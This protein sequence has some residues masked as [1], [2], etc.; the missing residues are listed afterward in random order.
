VTHVLV[1]PQDPAFKAPVKPVGAF[2]S[3]ELQARRPGW[4]LREFP[5][6]GWRR[7]VP[8]PRPLAVL[9]RESI[10]VLHDA[11]AIVVAAG[12]GGVPVARRDGRLSGVEA[13]VDKDLTS[14]LLA[15]DLGI[16]TLAI[17]TG[18]ERVQIDHGTPRAGATSTRS[19]RASSAPSPSRGSSPPAAW[20]PKVE[21]ALEFP[22]QGWKAGS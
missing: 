12:G 9:E 16:H 15:S 21:A 1:D 20:A 3:S 11:G 19:R 8:S 6:R 18:V 22:R 13:V 17:L 7:V 10:R 5:P 4:V 2:Y 14:A